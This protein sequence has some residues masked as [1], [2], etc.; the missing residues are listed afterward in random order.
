MKRIILFP[1]ILLIPMILLATPKT[2]ADLITIDPIFYNLQNSQVGMVLDIVNIDPFNPTLGTLDAVNVSISGLLTIYGVTGSNYSVDPF[3]NLFINPSV[4]QLKVTQNLNSIGGLFE[5]DM[6]ASFNYILYDPGFPTI[7]FNYENN[8]TYGFRFDDFFSSL[9]YTYRTN[10]G[11]PPLGPIQIYGD[12]ENFIDPSSP[13]IPFLGDL[14]IEQ[15]LFLISG[16]LPTILG[17]IITGQINIEYD[18]TPFQE[19][20][21]VPEPATMLLLASGLAGLVG[22]RRRFRKR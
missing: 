14:Y 7:P 20:T 16:N 10:P 11:E 5:F 15:D 1:L 4:L 18:Y 3:G 8:F 12:R 9:G 22:F 2:H 13:Y 6:P 17:S 19:S 21:P